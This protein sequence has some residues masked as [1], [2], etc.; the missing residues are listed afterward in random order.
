MT[1]VELTPETRVLLVR[2]LV[3]QIHEGALSD[4]FVLAYLDSKGW[5]P[6]A[7]A[8]TAAVRAHRL[9]RYHGDDPIGFLETLE[10]PRRDIPLAS[11]Y[12]RADYL[13]DELVG[14]LEFNLTVLTSDVMS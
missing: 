10:I 7:E 8:L 3:E 13:R 4:I 1:T 11:L 2:T 6:D 12:E 14:D 5:N 9:I